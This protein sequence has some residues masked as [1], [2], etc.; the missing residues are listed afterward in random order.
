[1]PNAEME[2]RFLTLHT[3][4]APEALKEKL[5]RWEPCSHRF[6]FDNGM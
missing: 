4:L 6:D 5:Q 1:L 3:T 2:E